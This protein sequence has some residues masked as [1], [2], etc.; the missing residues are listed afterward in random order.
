MGVFD[1]LKKA[2]GIDPNKLPKALLDMQKHRCY[3]LMREIYSISNAKRKRTWETLKYTGN[4]K[5]EALKKSDSVLKIELMDFLTEYMGAYWKWRDDKELYYHEDWLAQ[6][7]HD[8]MISFMRQ[9]IDFDAA[10][11]IQYL[12]DYKKYSPNSIF[13]P[14]PLHQAMMQ[15][16]KLAKAGK[17]EPKHVAEI[18][19]I[20]QWEEFNT[21]YDDAL[22]AKKRFQNI[23]HLSSGEAETERG[24]QFNEEDP[25]GVYANQMLS[26]L[27]KEHVQKYNAVLQACSGATQAKPSA[28]FLKSVKALVDELSIAQFKK[29]TLPLFEFISTMKHHDKTVHYPEDDYTYTYQVFLI[30]DNAA[31]IKGL[32]WTYSH[33]YDSQSIGTLAKLCER[34]FQKIPGVGPASAAIGNACIYTLARSKGMEG[35]GYLSR[36]KLVIKQSNT[37][38]LIQKYIDELS[39][40]LNVSPEE[41]E[42]IS[43]QDFDLVKGEKVVVFDDYKLRVY[44]DRIG[45]VAVQWIKPDGSIQ[46]TPPAIVKSS[47]SLSKKLADVKKEVKLIAKMVTTARDQLDRSMV[48]NRELTWEYFQQYYFNHGLRY[49]LVKDLLWYIESADKS[50]TVFYHNDQ[51]IN[52]QD[53]VVDWMDSETKVRLWHP[54]F[55]NADEI[56]AWRGKLVDLQVKQPLKQAF[57]EIY[58]LTEAEINT[59]LYSNR[60]ASH[61]IK[62]H[63]FNVLTSIRG[64]KYQLM[65]WF[66]DGRDNDIASKV[67]KKYGLT[68][69]FWIVEMAAEDDYND[70]GIW[71]YVSTDQVRFVDESGNPVEL[72]NIPKIVLSEILRDVDLF[73][74][75]C[76]VG[77]DPQWMDNGG[78]A[79]HRDY[80]QSYSFGDLNEIAKTR[81]TILENLVPKLKIGKVSRIEGKFLIVQGK[82][83]TYKI[84]IGSTNILMEPNDQYL[85]IVPSRKKDTS[86]DKVFLPFDG[87]KG[88]SLVI[89]KAMLLADDDKI[90]DSTIVSQLRP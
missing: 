38:K 52:L 66:D 65:G 60:M 44:I 28:R 12:H 55:C 67:L 36:L 42:D 16:E 26:E 30:K 20:A 45:S 13:Y 58:L 69:E 46:K 8:F 88:L 80:W 17:I 15:L 14:F 84:H 9:K 49:F 7:A 39:E 34:C 77:N 83:R 5:Y 64:W 82:I 73:V 32:V 37:Q 68:A 21:T 29:I 78:H 62:Q 63:Q 11:L 89:S 86:T 43:A 72:I 1:S 70:A 48:N 50:D 57:R 47:T 6:M 75:V 85:C 23:L 61:I 79:Q 3:K 41:V 59:R 76:S 25:F 54:V 53:D 35:V 4:E 18:R 51:W 74:G 81:K 19:S 33:F 71:H 87:D 24:F 27:K 90:T 56:M 10:K 31:V 40:K 22:K 2:V